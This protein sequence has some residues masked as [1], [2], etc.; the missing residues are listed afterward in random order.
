MRSVYFGLLCAGMVLLVGCEATVDPVVGTDKAFSL[1]GVL[2]PRADTQWVRVYPIEDRL[3]PTAPDSLAVTVTSTDLTRGRRATWHDSLIQEDDGRY[4]HVY[5]SR[6]PIE[7]EHTYRVE[8]AGEGERTAQV[9]VP[10]P[11]NAALALHEPQAETLPVIVPVH[12]TQAV[13]R[14]I[15]VEVEYYV[16]YDRQDNVAGSASPTARLRVSYSGI[17]ERTDGEWVV[18]IDLTEDYRT[19]RERL[20]NADLWNPTVGIVMRNMTLRLEV[21]ND[22]W[23]PPGGAFDPD[24][25]VEPGTMSNV[26]DGFGFVGAGYRLKKQW[27]PSVEVLERAGWT[28]PADLY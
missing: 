27:T 7:Y 5:W 11:E 15:N 26:T 19:L 2:Q 4:A 9:E 25:L 10:V 3:E 8:V 6:T 20:V 21:V 23:N 24:V 28:D 12:V 1:Y 18:P 16:Q 22:A 17:P 13:P 14:L